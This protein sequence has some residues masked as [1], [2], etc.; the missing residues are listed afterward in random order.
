MCFGKKKSNKIAAEDRA[1]IER[2]ANAVGVLIALCDCKEFRV[3]QE[4]LKYLKPSD[5][6]KALDYE[7][8]I[9]NAL[10]DAKIELKRAKNDQTKVVSDTVRKI[11]CLIAERRT[12]M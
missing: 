7:A 11:E 12:I 3:L 4:K 6:K 1:L 10:D 8:K 2:N 9:K 5:N